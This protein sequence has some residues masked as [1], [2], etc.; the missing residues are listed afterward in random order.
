MI[1]TCTKCSRDL[2]ATLEFFYNNGRNKLEARCKLCKN[3][4]KQEYRD[5]HKEKIKRDSKKY[6]H[7]HPN[8]RLD[9]GTEI[10]YRAL[11]LWVQYNKKKTKY[12]FICNEKKKLELSSIKHIYTRNL[13]DWLW[14]C[15]SCHMLFDKLTITG[16]E[17]RAK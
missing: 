12:C 14:L 15:Q 10:G 5:T 17:K 7:F 1:K 9:D 11:H 8:I 13:E 2:P 4:E 3:I 6:N 16:R